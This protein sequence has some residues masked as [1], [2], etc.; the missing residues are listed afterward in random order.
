[1]PAVRWRDVSI[2][3][4]RKHLTALTALV[5]A[6][7][8]GRDLKTCDPALIGPDDRVPLSNMPNSQRRLVRYGWLRVLFSKAEDADEPPAPANGNQ[9]NSGRDSAAPTRP[10]TTQLLHDARSR[11]VHDLAQANSFADTAPSH[12]MERETMKQVLSG[13]EFRD[14]E[15]ASARE[16]AL[17]KLDNWLNR[18]FE[19]AAKL[20]ARSAWIGGA[21]VWGFV[22]GVCSGLVL[23]LFR[24]ERRWRARLAFYDEQP[25]S[26]AA[27]ARDWQL[28]L[29]DA[30]RAATN[31]HWREAFHCMYWACIS[32]LESSRLWPADRAR[33]PREYLAL[34]APGDPRKSALEQLTDGFE[35]TWYGH[36]PTG[37]AEFQIAEKIASSLMTGGNS[38]YPG[39]EVRTR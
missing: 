2:G 37:P 39:S 31:G 26:A 17:E 15:Q 12:T 38:E 14:L 27:S 6:C 9:V 22:L 4:Y 18:L 23:I 3:D 32:C 35:R 1:M 34:L 7:A 19:R 28:W 5:D 16:T 33:T 21:I 20:K 10:T 30:R 36:H 29:E 8:K 13:P 11:L 25:A 24:L